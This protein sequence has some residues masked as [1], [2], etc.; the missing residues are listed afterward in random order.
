M[1]FLIILITVTLIIM[2]ITIFRQNKAM[3]QL[4]LRISLLEQILER[5]DNGSTNM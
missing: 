3:K 1:T 2:C 4:L 5:Y